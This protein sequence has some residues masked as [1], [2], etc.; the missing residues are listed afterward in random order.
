MTAIVR[1]SQIEVGGV[2]WIKG[3]STRK[4]PIPPQI[5]H[6]ETKVLRDQGLGRPYVL[7]TMVMNLGDLGIRI[8]DNAILYLEA[9]GIYEDGWSEIGDFNRLAHL[10]DHDR[11]L[12]KVPDTFVG[13]FKR[14]RPEGGYHEIAMAKRG[15]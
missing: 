7:G 4:E 12:E 6:V 14:I 9:V 8:V 15:A 11:H 5:I 3:D 1:V 13:M 10:L 2:Y